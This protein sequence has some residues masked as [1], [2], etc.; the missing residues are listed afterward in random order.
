MA[1]FTY[2]GRVEIA[3]VSRGKTPPRGTGSRSI[4]KHIEWSTEY[5]YLLKNKNKI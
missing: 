3:A 4:D 1:H 5:N 2:F